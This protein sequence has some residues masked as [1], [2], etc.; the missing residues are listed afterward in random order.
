MQFVVILLG[1]IAVIYFSKFDT[2]AM[3]LG[4][5]LIVISVYCLGKYQIFSKKFTQE[6]MLYL[7]NNGWK[8]KVNFTTMRTLPFTSGLGEN[9]VYYNFLVGSKLIT[10]RKLDAKRKELNNRYEVIYT[11]EYCIL[12]D[13]VN[14]THVLYSKI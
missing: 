9:D 10:I 12:T 1:G 11:D 13:F 3:I 14:T 5:F 6:A 2:L 4:V 7:E 8:R